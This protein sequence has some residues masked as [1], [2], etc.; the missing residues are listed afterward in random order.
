MLLEILR[1]SFTLLLH[2]SKQ[3]NVSASRNQRAVCSKGQAAK[4]RTNYQLLRRR[5]FQPRALMNVTKFNL[6]P[7]HKIFSTWNKVRVVFHF[8]WSVTV[9]YT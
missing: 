8:E 9:V 6:L 5:L 3:K 4:N 2:E 1:L 7:V